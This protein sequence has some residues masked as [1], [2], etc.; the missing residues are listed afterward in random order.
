MFG[1]VDVVHSFTIA[2]A[3]EPGYAFF[4]FG[5]LPTF[6]YPQSYNLMDVREK[7]TVS[8]ITRNFI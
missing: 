5:H 6:V 8:L 4:D 1:A 2:F 3:V 7:F